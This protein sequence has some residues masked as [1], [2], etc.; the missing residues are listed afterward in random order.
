[1]RL[2]SAPAPAPSS[3]LRG[4]AAPAVHDTAVA[5][6]AANVSP[7]AEDAGETSPFGEAAANEIPSSLEPDF[8]IAEADE[9]IELIE[10]AAGQSAAAPEPSIDEPSAIP[11]DVYRAC[12]TLSGSSKMAQAR[13]G[14]RL[15]EPLDHWLRRVY[16]SGLG[17]A[18]QD[19]ALLSDCMAAMESV[20]S[21]LDETT[22]Y[23]VSHWELQQRIGQAEAMLDQRLAAAHAPGQTAASH[24]HA[25]PA[26]PHGTTPAPAAPVAE[27]VPEP[28][29]EESVEDAGD[30]DPEVAAIF[31]E[32]AL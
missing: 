9:P 12:H 27:R 28:P 4:A 32:E 17:L 8:V 31:T 11:E 6:A 13:H 3:E 25:P 7:A 16:S 14:I 1:E 10:D 5:G 2:S 24:G 15:A 18:N 21:H 19:L 26:A 29:A 23:F 22:G 20:A 30:F